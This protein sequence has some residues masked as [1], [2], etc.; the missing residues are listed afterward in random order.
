LTTR[1][2]RRGDFGARLVTVAPQRSFARPPG[3]SQIT[4]LIRRSR[5]PA[6][7]IGR[8]IACLEALGDAEQALHGRGLPDAFRGL[9]LIDTLVDIVGAVAGLARLGVAQLS[10]S[11]VNLG[12][13]MMPAHGAH[14]QGHHHGPLPLPAPAAVRLLTGYPV[15]SDG[16]A[17]ELTTPTGAALIRVLAR[18]GS[19][20]PMRLVRVGH[21]AGHR[22]LDPWPNLVRLFIG[23][24]LGAAG[25]PA[26]NGATEETIMQIETDLDDYTPQFFDY[27]RDRLFA[28]GALDVYLTPVIMKQGR[29]A[30]QVTLLTRPERAPELMALL[31]DE[32]TTLGVRAQPVQRWTLPRRTARLTTPDGLVR[33][34]LVQTGRGVEARPEYRDARAIAERTG[35]PLRAVMRRLEALAQQRFG[36]RAQSVR[37]MGGIG[38]SKRHASP[39]FRSVRPMGGIGGSKRRAP[40]DFK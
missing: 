1:T 8:S 31:F 7:V 10:V 21:G 40:P 16:P 9:E 20:P 38:G 33:V 29:P 26:P 32:T 22:R 24:E 36:K 4:R 23:E 34:K 28:G 6:P 13:G 2:V 3:F 39:D 18:G 37:P 5:L 25:R 14:G 11:P 19:L 35:R 17:A 27:L 15:Y 12:G 30:T